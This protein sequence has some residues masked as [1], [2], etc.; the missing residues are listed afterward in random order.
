MITKCFIF[1]SNSFF[2][3]VY[4]LLCKGTLKTVHFSHVVAAF[5]L[6]NQLMIDANMSV[7]WYVSPVFEGTASRWLVT[8][9]ILY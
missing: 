7:G 8:N 9:N 3:E 4:K 2:N 1:N 5:Y 6:D